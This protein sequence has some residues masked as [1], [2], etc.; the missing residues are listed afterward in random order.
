MEKLDIIFENKEILVVNKP[1]K[2]LTISDGKTTNTLYSKASSYVKKQHKSNKV[3]IVHRL[4][5]DT[6]GVVLF[7]KNE[8]IK[9]ELQDNWQNIS[10]RYYVGIV[11]G[12]INNDK[13]VIKEYLKETKTH[14]VYAVNDKRGDY[15]ESR[16]QVLNRLKNNTVLKIEIITGRKNQIRVGLKDLG[17]PL[18]GDKKYESKSNPIN[19]LG[20]HAAVLEIII[21]GEKYRFVAKCPKEFRRYLDEELYEREFR[22]T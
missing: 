19:R 7:A 2:M 13:G 18:I 6:S 20:L 4:D 12:V 3:F 15:A 9:K 17:Y 14:L 10:K 1:A 11:Q 5:K 16:Y 22:E 8:K 21:H